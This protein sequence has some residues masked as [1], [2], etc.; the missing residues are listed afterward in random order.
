MMKEACFSNLFLSFLLQTIRDT[1][2]LE[3]KLEIEVVWIELVHSDVTVFTTTSVC[4]SVLMERQRI[5]GT[6][7]TLDAA[8]FLFE[9]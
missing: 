9:N 8:E 7:V 3:I 4:F 1:N 2:V 5:Y 6:E